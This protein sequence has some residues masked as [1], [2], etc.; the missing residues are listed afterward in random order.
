[1]IPLMFVVVVDTQ[2]AEGRT[3]GQRGDKHTRHG[4]RG[5][6]IT[7]VAQVR[8]RKPLTLRRFNLE[9]VAALR[10]TSVVSGESMQYPIEATPAPERAR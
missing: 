6:H 1:M 2:G 5:G 4:P 7:P 9:A 10:L 3:T 8:Q